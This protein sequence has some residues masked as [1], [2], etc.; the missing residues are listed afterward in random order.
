MRLLAP[1]V[2][3][4]A[5][6][7]T[8][9]KPVVLLDAMRAD[10]SIPI[11]AIDAPQSTPVG[12]NTFG[13]TPPLLLAFRD[14]EGLWAALDPA[15]Q[16]FLVTQPTYELLAVCAQGAAFVTGIAAQAV[17]DGDVFMP[18]FSQSSG[19]A[20]PTVAIT[21]QMAQPGTV[22]MYESS[23]GTTSPWTYALDV[24]PGTHDFIAA[25]AAKIAIIRNTSISIAGAGPNVDV[26][27]TGTA[28]DSQTFT[29]T[30]LGNGTVTNDVELGTAHE[31]ITIPGTSATV[32][33][34]PMAVLDPATDFV[35]VDLT[36][37]DGLKTQSAQEF[38]QG[39]FEPTVQ[40]LPELTGVTFTNASAT[41]TTL[42]S[43]FDSASLQVTGTTGNIEE[44]TAT[45]AWLTGATA[46]AIELTNVP[47]YMAAWRVRMTGAVHEFSIQESVSQIT[48]VT[49]SV[50]DGTPFA[51][52]KRARFE[53][54]RRSRRSSARACARRSA[55]GASPS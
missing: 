35:L 25:D 30:N 48:T 10:S 20:P 8:S 31:F 49:T 5:C 33:T 26:D 24:T 54:A 50:R 45:P 13:G 47:G 17:S 18:C 46:L 19:T 21:G 39:S 42:P 28:F 16:T 37:T 22:W 23:A 43:T 6:G 14:G 34:L 52:D 29:L 11:D 44:I 41:W 27:A 12:I 32:P 3:V 9:D 53:R 1:L 36:A 2:L 51:S 40:L 15:A 4:T 7:G 38:Y 55:R